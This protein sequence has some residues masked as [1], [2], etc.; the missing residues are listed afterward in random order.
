MVIDADLPIDDTKDCTAVASDYLASITP[1]VFEDDN[2]L[3]SD[4]A[5]IR[6]LHLSPNAPMVD[7]QLAGGGAVVSV[8]YLNRRKRR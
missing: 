8:Y 1:L 4:K 3:I 6:F 2:T 7:V 5:R